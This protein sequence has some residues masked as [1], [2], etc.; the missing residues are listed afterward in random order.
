MNDP[1]LQNFPNWVGEEKPLLWDFSSLCRLFLSLLFNEEIEFIPGTGQ[2]HNVRDVMFT[3]SFFLEEAATKMIS[4]E[5]V[6]CCDSYHTVRIFS[7]IFSGSWAL[8]YQNECFRVGVSFTAGCESWLRTIVAEG[9]G[10]RKQPWGTWTASFRN[11]Q[12]TLRTLPW[13]WWDG[14]VQLMAL[15]CSY[16]SHTGRCGC[17]SVH[18]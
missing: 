2:K 18:T 6:S 3:L 1:L 16:V 7:F 15:G 4:M 8:L 10:D 5:I 12:M 17:L 9:V 14:W 11:G 13:A